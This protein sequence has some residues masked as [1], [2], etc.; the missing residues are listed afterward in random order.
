M[1][2]FDT[3][4]ALAGALS[5]VDGVTGYPQRPGA[6]RPGD[7]WPLW[8]GSERSDGMAFLET[9]AVVVALAGDELAADTFADSKR[10]DLD[11]ALRPVMWV[12]SYTPA[13][14]NTEAGDMNAL[15]I[16]GRTE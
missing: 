5:M 16:T 10:A 3:R 13:V 4:I 6:V 2:N 9:W 14:V 8:R 15:M 1:T 7:A 12:E 11:D